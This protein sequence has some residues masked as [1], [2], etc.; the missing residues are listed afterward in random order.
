MIYAL[1]FLLLL[2]PFISFS[3][4]VSLSFSFY[5]IQAHTQQLNYPISF[6]K[7]HYTLFKPEIQ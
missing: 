4:Q 1:L 2:S 6:L 7:I 5:I 3:A